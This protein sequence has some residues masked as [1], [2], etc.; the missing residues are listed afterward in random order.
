MKTN[1]KKTKISSKKE[2][3]RKEKINPMMI[4]ILVLIVIQLLLTLSMIFPTENS[5]DQRIDNIETKV[6]AIDNFFRSNVD[7]YDSTG[8]T[9]VQPSSQGSTPGEKIEVSADDDPWLGSDNA[10]VTVIEFSDY[11]C[12][13]CRK[14]WTESYPL[15][16]SEYIDTGK[17]KYVFRDFPLNFHPGAPL[18]AI[19][20]NCVREQLGNDGYFKYHDIAFSEQNKLGQGTIQFTEG[21][22]MSWVGQIDGIDKTEF[23][24]CYNDPAQKAEVDADFAAGAAAGVSGTPSFFINGEMLVGA[25]PYSVI[26]ATIEKA[27]NE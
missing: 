23:D 9:V 25:Q 18:A 12:P 6:N 17:I 27:L 14:Y 10:K 21:D 7:G 15:L 16:K 8:S 13:F 19:A 24:T 4:G 3:G 22:V 5:S 2:L 26:K 20:G 11:Q 1:A